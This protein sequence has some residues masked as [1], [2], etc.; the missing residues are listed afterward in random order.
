MK[1]QDFENQI[2][3]AFEHY[4]PGMSDDEIWDNIEPHLKKKKRRRWIIWFF[5]GLGVLISG[6]ALNQYQTSNRMIEAP[7]SAPVTPANDIINQTAAPLVITPEPSAEDKPHASKAET[8]DNRQKEIFITRQPAKPSLSTNAPLELMEETVPEAKTPKFTARSV[9]ALSALPVLEFNVAAIDDQEEEKERVLKKRKKPTTKP[10]RTQWH[11]F[12][13]PS[14]GPLLAYKAMTANSDFDLSSYRTNRRETEKQLEAFS[15]A[16]HTQVQNS[17]GLLL[18]IGM[19]YQRLNERFDYRRLEFDQSTIITPIT[20][21][22]NALGE[23]IRTTLGTVQSTTTLE[24]RIQHHNHYNFIYVPIGAGKIWHRPKNSWSL[25]GG[26]DL[27]V[28]F[29]MKGR[30]LNE[31]SAPISVENSWRRNDVFK[32]KAGTG[33]WLA[34]GYYRPI[35]KQLSWSVTPKIQLPLNDLTLDDYALS[36]RYFRLSLNMGVRYYWEGE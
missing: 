31:N 19:E 21:T 7:V 12:L 14:A 4:P 22:E 34:V 6:I 18:T 28:A 8:K 13:Q 25:L 23:V 17:K 20:I 3:Q 29:Q 36:Q 35:N 2:R 27:N 30:L 9:E 5:F 11:T 10:L 32:R 16:F 33:L 15:I 26:V 24:H 1:Q